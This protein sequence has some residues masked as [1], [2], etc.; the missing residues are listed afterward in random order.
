LNGSFTIRLAIKLAA[1][2]AAIVIGVGSGYKGL[3]S[4][5]NRP[6]AGNAFWTTRALNLQDNAL[7]YTT[8][9]YLAHGQLPPPLAVQ[10]F[11]RHADDDGR[12]LDGDCIIEVK[13]TIPAARWWTLS[14]VDGEGVA[15]SDENTLTAGSAVIEADDTLVLRIA[16]SPQPGNWIKPPTRGSYSIAYTL[17]EAAPQQGAGIA[18]PSVKRV[19]C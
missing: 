9:H 13:G 16:S 3:A 12:A 17:H 18:L 8:G 1:L 11:L 7:P 19:G 5:G 14:A 15:I 6:V 2:V 10:D 4:F